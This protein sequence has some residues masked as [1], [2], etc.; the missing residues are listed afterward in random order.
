M[1]LFY[2]WVIVA[3]GALTTCV[4][5]GS[6]FSLAVFLNPISADTG[7][8]TAGISGAMTFVFLVMGFA[9]FAWGA[10]SD[11]IG[12]RPVVLVAALL[13]GFG[14]LLASRAES[15]LE[16]QLAYGLLVGASAGAFFAPLIATV[17][18]WFERHRGLAISLV[19]AGIGV[20]PMTISP[21]AGWLIELYGW[22]SAMATIAVAAWVLLVPA[23]LL[24]R[25]PPETASEEGSAPGGAPHGGGRKIANSAVEALSSSRFAILALTFFLC[26]GAHSGPIFHTVN[27]ATICGIP[28]A[29]AIG[30]YSLEGVA[31]LFGRLLL[32]VM[33][34][35][36][37]AKPVLVGGLA[38]QAAAIWAYQYV[39]DLAGFYTVAFVFGTAYGGVMPLYA[40][41]ARD[42]FGP[43]VM[44]TV[45][46]AATLASSMAMAVGPLAGGWVLDAFHS[47]GWLYA[48]SAAVALAAVVAALGFP[49]PLGKP[50]RLAAS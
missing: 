2:G 23:A 46:G 28:T 47:Y 9:G 32:G 40:V 27:Y 10:A 41:L 35:R 25:R 29:A 50:D 7:W 42:Y 39:G 6:A 1:R 18:I 12:A 11:R 16:F 45:L 15:V 3:V 31:G 37:G 44:G 8:S 43:R 5:A 13:L 24:I 30:I 19:S 14:L 38:V 21:F 33:G 34:D 22:R 36:F 26:C 49:P 48:G 17:S 20:A 4:A